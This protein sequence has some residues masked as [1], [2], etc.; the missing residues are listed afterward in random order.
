M[1]IAYSVLLAAMFLPFVYTGYAKFSSRG[2]N[3]ARV[4]EFQ[5]QLDGAARRAHHAHL[6]SFEAYPPFAVAVLLAHQMQAAQATVDVLA[7]AWLVLR[8]GYGWAYISDRP[9]LRSTLWALALI[10]VMGL[11]WVS[12]SG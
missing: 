11:W 3:N 6:N 5:E 8:L 4:R 12:F 7:V 10:A 1:T 2:Y 9:S